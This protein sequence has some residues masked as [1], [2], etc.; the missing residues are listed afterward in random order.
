[1]IKLTGG[2]R[3]G[4]INVTWPFATLIATPDYL[5]IKAP[6]IGNQQ[7]TASEIIRLET[8][9]GVISKGVRIF[10]SKNPDH[11]K[12]IFWCFGNPQKVIEKIKGCG[13]RLAQDEGN[14]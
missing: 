4:A 3:V 5:E 11:V 13:F 1:M 2:A 6:M 14:A 12:V 8:Y 7:Y 9:Q 10:S